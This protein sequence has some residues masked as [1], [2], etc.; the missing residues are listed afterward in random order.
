[1]EKI[2]KSINAMAIYLR[3]AQ[4]TMSILGCKL[5]SLDS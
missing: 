2:G 3:F 4:R 1:M 5:D